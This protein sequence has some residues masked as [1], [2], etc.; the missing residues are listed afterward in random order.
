MC[1]KAGMTEF[2]EELNIKEYAGN[3]LLDLGLRLSVHGTVY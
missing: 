3:S 2:A 1:L